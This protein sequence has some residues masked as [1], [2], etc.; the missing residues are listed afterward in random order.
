[1][2]LAGCAAGVPKVVVKL[3][4]G[5]TTAADSL[6]PFV[7]ATDAAAATTA[8]A[9]AL[10]AGGTAGDAAAAAALALTVAL[11]SSAS[12]HAGGVCLIYD[13]GAKSMHRL[14]FTGPLATA[15]AAR[16]IHG[17]LGA[18]PWP[19]AAAPAAVLAR[20]GVAVSPALAEQ[21]AHADVLLGDAQ[22]LSVFMSPRRQLLAPGELLRQPALADTLDRLRTAPRNGADSLPWAPAAADPSGDNHAYLV[23]K[24][25]SSPKGASSLVVADAHGNAVTCTFA[26]GAAFGAGAMRDGAL[27]PAAGATPVAARAVVDTKG[28]VVMIEANGGPGGYANRLDCFLDKGTPECEAKALAPGGYALTGQVGEP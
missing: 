25:T 16:T 4:E 11:P 1:M 20:F 26:L 9:A 10:R 15:H 19:R 21:L 3:G 12:L 23:G 5:D 7:I 6:R 8:G 28:R 27:Q 18:L 17:V 24:A 22:A 13:A 2:A 14:E